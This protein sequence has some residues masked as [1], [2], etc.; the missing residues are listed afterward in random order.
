MNK[1][2][3]RFDKLSTQC[4]LN[5]ASPEPTTSVWDEAFS[6]LLDIMNDGR[7]LD[8]DFAP[9]LCDL[10]ET[11]DFQFDVSG[12]LEDYLDELD[13]R[14]Q[15]EKLQKT[16]EKLLKLFRWQEDSP[17]DLRFRI[18]SAMGAQG[19]KEE[20]LTFCEKWYQKEPDNVQ[21]ITALIYAKI[22]AQDLTGAEQLVDKYISKNTVCS[23]ENDIIFTAASLLYKVNGNEKAEKRIEQAIEKYEKE[24]EAYFSD[25]GEDELDFL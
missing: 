25:T 2:W 3:K 15:Y 13:V 8:R 23:D 9:E 4:Y 21:G 10:E 24:V 18:A 14:E 20:A 1:A 19:K 16:C 7:S 5:M 22:G 11:I 6:V 17:S 12:W